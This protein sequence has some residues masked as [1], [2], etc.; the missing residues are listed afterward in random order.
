MATI[1]KLFLAVLAVYGSLILISCAPSQYKTLIA[2]NPDAYV[3]TIYAGVYVV[4]NT[5]E[6]MEV[7]FV[8]KNSPAEKAGIRAGDIIISVD[9]VKVKDR[10]TLFETI[11]EKKEPGDSALLILKRDGKLLNTSIQLSSIHF[12][13][14]QYILIKEA[15]KEKPLNL[16]IMVSDISNVYLQGERL[17]QWRRG[18]TPFIIG[19]LENSYLEFLKHEKKASIIDRQN[20]D[21]ALK[22]LAF[23]QTGLISEESQIKI[24][25]MLGATHLLIV[26]YSRF[27]HS[28][29]KANDVEVRRLIDINSGKT[30]ANVTLK[31]LID[32]EKEITPMQ[33]DLIS[34]QG[35]LSIIW[36]L[37][38]EAIEALSKVTGSNYTNDDKLDASLSSIVLPKYEDFVNQLAQIR[39][40]MQEVKNIH[41]IYVEGAK[42]QLESFKM[43]KEGID[44]QD[45]A[46]I[47]KADIMLDRGKEKIAEWQKRISALK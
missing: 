38:R 9:N 24:G 15:T 26:S 4:S 28:T 27:S 8:W 12:P 19:A 40:S 25:N 31:H 20:I 23:Q 3:E 45:V 11:Y 2:E 43:I 1:I 32:L 14:D 10:F 16:A 35:A 34:Y 39:P 17:E 22:E 30:I 6:E 5:N 13:K 47:K 37:E 33:Q 42:L 41:E 46:L 29:A 36:P 7:T 21:S 18:M 44:R